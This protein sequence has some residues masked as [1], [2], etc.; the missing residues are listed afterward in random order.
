V[1]VAPAHLGSRAFA[2]KSLN[3]NAA[4]IS[5]DGVRFVRQPN[6]RSQRRKAGTAGSYGTTLHITAYGGSS[7]HSLRTRHHRR[8]ARSRLARL[9]TTNLAPPT[10]SRA[11]GNHCPASSAVTGPTGVTSSRPWPRGARSP[12][13]K[14]ERISRR[15]ANIA[16]RWRA[17]C[18]ATALTVSTRATAPACSRSPTISPRST[19]GATAYHLT[20]RDG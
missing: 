12:C 15:A 2:R 13:F 9:A 10:S 19:N 18:A 8:A 4:G 7:P 1:A 6:R 17:G 3:Q 5:A 16:R 14:P 11:A 20:S